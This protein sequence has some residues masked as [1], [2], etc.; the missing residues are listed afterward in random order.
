[1]ADERN[2]L[3]KSGAMIQ[4]G[5]IPGPL[6]FPLR[7]FAPI[8]ARATNLLA[9]TSF[10]LSFRHLWREIDS[11]IRGPHHGALART[12]T[13]LAMSRDDGNGQMGMLDDRL[14]INWEHV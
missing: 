4:E 9:D 12:Q 11:A 1:M 6:Q 5:A 2:D 3:L 7:F 14:R 13:F 10:D 8:M